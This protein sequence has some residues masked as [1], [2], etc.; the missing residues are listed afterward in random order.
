MARRSQLLLLGGAVAAVILTSAAP[1]PVAAARPGF[2]LPFICGQTYQGTTYDGHGWAVDFNQ[3]SNRDAGDPVVASAAGTVRDTSWVTRNGQ[4]TIDHGGGWTT[5]YAHMSG[6]EVK[7]DQRVAAGQLLGYVDDVGN[8]TLDHLH[9][10]QDL[11]G[12][13]VQSRFDGVRY[14]YGTSITSTNCFDT[15]PPEVTAPDPG[16]LRGTTMRTSGPP[17]PVHVR[18]AV[19]D[20]LSGSKRTVLE[21]ETDGDGYL[22]M[23]T[24]SDASSPSFTSYLSGAGTSRVT[25]RVQA[26]DHAGN[27]SG[28]ATG[29]TIRS[30]AIDE[31]ARVPYLTYS[32]TGWKSV[33][34]TDAY[35]GGTARRASSAG[36]SVTF[37][38]AGHDFAIVAKKG[39]RMGKFRVYVD[40]VA[41]GVVDLY[42]R[43]PT[44]RKVVWQMGYA[45]SK[46]R[47][48]E[49]RV[50]GARNPASSGTTVE[51]DA[52]L[53]LQP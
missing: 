2:Q 13:R 24:A 43:A 23:F 22:H 29:P 7:L 38:Q 46:P 17:V 44:Y 15:S 36:E 35:F 19:T 12:V 51:L 14:E 16:F 49:L 42:H 34:D 18:W 11:D 9:Y 1:R 10:E 50:L 45:T 5:V 47:A 6:I 28:Y 3:P 8:A 32:D 53:V 26:T 25:D 27:V 30:L 52:F 31:S 39:P 40:G 37:T 21:R 33:T 20:A 48:V 4:I 41:A